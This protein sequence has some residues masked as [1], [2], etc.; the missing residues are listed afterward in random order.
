MNEAIGEALNLSRK[1]FMFKSLSELGVKAY[2]KTKVLNISLP[3]VFVS[4]NGYDFPIRNVDGVVVA[5]GRKPIDVLSKTVKER[6]PECRVYVIGDANLGGFAIDAI[7]DG[8]R[9][10]AKV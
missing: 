1:H 9:C 7:A 10:A 8:A 4:S 5:A 6:L 3:E 2:I